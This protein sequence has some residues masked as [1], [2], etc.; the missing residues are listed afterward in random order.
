[1]KETAKK[2]F[3]CLSTPSSFIQF[4]S[5]N[6]FVMFLFSFYAEI[7]ANRKTKVQ[8]EIHWSDIRWENHKQFFDVAV[9]FQYRSKIKNIFL[10]S[11]CCLRRSKRQLLLW[12][13]NRHLAFVFHVNKYVFVLS[14]CLSSEKFHSLKSCNR[15][16]QQQQNKKQ[17]KLRGKFISDV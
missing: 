1:M 7:I 6:D 4:L 2:C 13:S 11:C 17:K 8:T 14:H 5:M 9:H 3:S 16:L 12:M 10:Y 15:L